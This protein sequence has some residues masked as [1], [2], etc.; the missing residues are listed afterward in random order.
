VTKLTYQNPPS[1]DG[2]IYADEVPIAGRLARLGD[3]DVAFLDGLYKYVPA[4]ET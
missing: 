2:M 3:D 4:L 1:E